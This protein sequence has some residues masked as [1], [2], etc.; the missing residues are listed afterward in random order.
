MSSDSHEGPTGRTQLLWI[1]GG[2]AV[3]ALLTI[4]LLALREPTNFEPGTPEAVVQDYLQA[5]LD[6]DERSAVAFFAS[7]SAC[8]ADDFTN[9]RDVTNVRITLLET[10]TFANAEAAVDVRIRFDE[11]GLDVITPYDIDERFDLVIE[12]R[13][14]RITGTPWPLFFCGGPP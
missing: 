7:G 11:P 3:L 9:R 12:S 1:G 5:V 14:W 8:A 2:L 13:E 4:A 10:E 6:G